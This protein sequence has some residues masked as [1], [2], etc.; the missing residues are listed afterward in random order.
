LIDKFC[1]RDHE[2][3]FDIQYLFSHMLFHALD[4][5]L[6]YSPELLHDM[7]RYMLTYTIQF[8]RHLYLQL[9]SDILE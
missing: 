9:K 7:Q 6:K 8:L 1:L 3:F 2:L 4:F 5:L